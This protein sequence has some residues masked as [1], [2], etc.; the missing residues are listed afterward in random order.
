MYKGRSINIRPQEGHSGTSHLFQNFL[1]ISVGELEIK[2]KDIL[3]NERR[4]Y[5]KIGELSQK[6]LA[7]I[8]RNSTENE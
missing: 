1:R 4:K 7:S 6:Y 8:N 3:I 5:K 2:I